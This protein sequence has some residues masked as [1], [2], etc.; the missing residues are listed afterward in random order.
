MKKLALSL[1]LLAAPLGAQ[2]LTSPPPASLGYCYYAAGKEFLPIAA[3]SGGSIVLTNPPPASL[4]FGNYAAGPN[5]QPLQ[6]DSGGNLIISGGS[7]ALVVG[8]TP[9]T[10]GTN[11]QTL[12]DNNGVLGS[13][14][15]AATATALAATPAQCPA[16]QVATGVTAAGVANCVPSTPGIFPSAA[17]TLI[18]QCRASGS[19]TGPWEGYGCAVSAVSGGTVGTAI[20]ATATTPYL[21]PIA[22][23]TGSG[24]YGGYEGGMAFY[25]SLTPSLEAGVEFPS[26]SDILS[27]RIFVGYSSN[28]AVN[29]DTPNFSTGGIVFSTVASDTSFM[30]QA[31]SATG[32]I[33][34]TS[35]G[36]TPVAGTYYVMDVTVNPGVSVVCV[37]NGTTTTVTTTLPSSTIAMGINLVTITQSTTATHI[38]IAKWIGEHLTGTI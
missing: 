35:M 12:Y 21:Y 19:T 27:T 11:A 24:Q 28:T 14:G 23:L 31:G 16:G 10:S 33:T 7:S 25:S 20:A 32:S 3:G 18:E 15:N 1:F 5:Y 30:C 26:A 34:R 4:V 17:P 8:T 29:T 9:V 22:T 36:V 13:G 6:C 2:T 38:A 37:V